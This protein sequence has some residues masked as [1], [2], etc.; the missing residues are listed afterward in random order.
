MKMKKVLAICLMLCMSL[1]LLAGCGGS[2]QDQTPPPAD[3]SGAADTDSGNENP[4][5]GHT[6]YV[7]NWQGY[8]F[9]ANY[10]KKAFEDKFSCKVE[11]VYFDS[12]D[13]LMTNLQTGGNATVMMR[14]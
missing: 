1:C 5:E 12:Y 10:C 2:G 9:D 7:A 6:L 4:Y 8:C 11:M 13:D 14:S 3:N